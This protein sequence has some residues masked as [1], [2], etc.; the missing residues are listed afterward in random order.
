MITNKIYFNN[1]IKHGLLI[2][3]S[4]ISGQ[5]KDSDVCEFKTKSAKKVILVATQQFKQ[6]VN[7]SLVRKN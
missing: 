7:C 2:T 4:E 1:I 6:A 3:R 5:K